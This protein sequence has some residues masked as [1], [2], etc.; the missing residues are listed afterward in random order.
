MA[1]AIKVKEAS[2][3]E[4]KKALEQAKITHSWDKHPSIHKTFCL[5]VRNKDKNAA[6][7]AIEE[8]PCKILS[9]RNRR[10]WEQIC[11]NN[12]YWESN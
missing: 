8:I 9:V 3:D 2:Y 7:E 10:H 11:S 4:A 6:I 12:G 1:K 5:I